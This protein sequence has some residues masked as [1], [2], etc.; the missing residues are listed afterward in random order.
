MPARKIFVICRDENP[1][2]QSSTKKDG[3]KARK[4]GINDSCYT[5]G[6]HVFTILCCCSLAMSV[7][8]LIPRHNSILEPAYWF[9]VNIPSAMACFIVTTM[10]VLD[11]IVI[12]EKNSLVTIQFFLMTYLA[13]YLTVTTCY[14]T[15]YII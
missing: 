4:S 13:T 2:K 7:L 3:T 1:K 9:E 11:F 12:F 14:C 8:T 10:I 5:G 6:L 15:I